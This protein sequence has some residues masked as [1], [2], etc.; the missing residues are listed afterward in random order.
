MH[1]KVLGVEIRKLVGM[2]IN[3][4]QSKFRH[5]EGPDSLQYIKGPAASL[6]IELLEWAKSIVRMTDRPIRQGLPFVDYCNASIG[7]NSVEQDVAAD[8]TGQ[9]K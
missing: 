2:G 8:R 1:V 9:E 7:R 4:A 5:F 6:G 3:I